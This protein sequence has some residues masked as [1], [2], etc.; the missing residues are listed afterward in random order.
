MD[1]FKNSNSEALANSQKR[2]RLKKKIN[3]NVK[4]VLKLL[5]VFIISLLLK[6]YVFSIS[7][8]R[9]NSMNDT[10]QDGD[11]LIV[12]RINPTNIK[13]GDIVIVK[14]PDENS[15]HKYFIKRVIAFENDYV[16]IWKNILLVNDEILD[17][18]YVTY[19][20]NTSD[21]YSSLTLHIPKGHIFVLGDNRDF[22]N[23]SRN[24]GSIPV[25]N[26]IAKVYIR[27][28]PFDK[29]GFVE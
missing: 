21:K 6:N 26:I 17:E 8:V 2:K 15:D 9:Q 7:V 12:S 22:S 28:Y 24:F 3:D 18:E 10:L 19:N 1:K 14:N 13:K 23:D 20:R 4:F 29:F 11:I 5:V 27:I 16:E 25:K